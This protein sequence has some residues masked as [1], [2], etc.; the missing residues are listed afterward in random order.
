MLWQLKKAT[1]WVEDWELSESAQFLLMTSIEIS[2]IYLSFQSAEV[3]CLSKTQ[4]LIQTKSM[5]RLKNTSVHMLFYLLLC[6]S[7]A[8]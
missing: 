6:E 8:A 2:L 5:N 7:E 3:E 4:T 1:C